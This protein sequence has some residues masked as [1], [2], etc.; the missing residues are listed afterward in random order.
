MLAP[1]ENDVANSV[2][3][4]VKRN[5]IVDGFGVDESSI[6]CKGEIVEAVRVFEK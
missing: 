3:S 6:M 4:V 2:R 1:D 5:D